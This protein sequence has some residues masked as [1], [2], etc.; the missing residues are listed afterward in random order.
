L[1]DVYCF[2]DGLKLPFEACSGLTK[3][4]RY[5]NGWQH[6]H[7][8]TNVL[9]FGADGSIIHAVLNVPGS[10]PDSQVALWGGT[11]KKLRDIHAKTGSVCCV[12]STFAALKVPYLIQSSQDTTKAKDAFHQVQMTEAI[13]L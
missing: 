7:Y 4:G 8:I 3:Q 9:V 6:G 11:H 2:A 12:D 1:K 5:Y 10:V 13:S